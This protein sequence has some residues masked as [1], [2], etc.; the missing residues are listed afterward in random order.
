MEEVKAFASQFRKQNIATVIV[1]GED[2]YRIPHSL[3]DKLWSHCPNFWEK[4]TR[5]MEVERSLQVQ[6]ITANCD[7]FE[8]FL[9]WASELRLP[10]FDVSKEDIT[11]D[12]VSTTVV[13]CKYTEGVLADLWL[14]AAEFSIPRL[15]NEA[16]KRLLEVLFE[17]R[18]RPC[19]LRQ[20]YRPSGKTQLQN[21]LQ[22][23]VAHG[24]CCDCYAAQEENELGKVDGFLSTFTSLVRGRGM[25]DP[26][27]TSPSIQFTNGGDISAFMV[28]EE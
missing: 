13:E 12:D 22:L 20:F 27:E 24:L 4:L 18:V 11:D 26:K 28:P 16:M 17:V 10:H 19:T 3:R 21:V 14:F 2:T 25:L 5:E 8:L 7:V 9:F 6:T 15:Q 1:D 23:E